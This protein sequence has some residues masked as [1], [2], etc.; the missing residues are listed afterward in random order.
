MKSKNLLAILAAFACFNLPAV[1]DVIT[2]TGATS[3]S[4]QTSGNRVIAK[5]IDGSGLSNV[6]DP[7]SELDDVHPY[8]SSTTDSPYWLSSGAASAEV[9]TFELGGSHDID[10]VYYWMYTRDKNRNPRTFDISYSTDG[11]SSFST[12]VSAASLNMADW[13]QSLGT[14]EESFAELR[15]LD[16][17]TGVTHIRFTNIQVY[18]GGSNLVGLHEIRFRGQETSVVAGPVDAGTSTVV[19]SP[20]AVLADGTSTSTITVTLKDASGIAVSGEDVT[21]ANTSGPGTPTIS[22]SATQT[23]DGSGVAT[24]TVSS[25]AVGTEVFSATSSTDS[26]T[27][28]QTASVDFQAMTVDAASSTVSASPTSVTANDTDTSS[29]TVTVRNAGGLPLPGMLVVLSGDSSATITP[30][31]TGTDTTDA[32]G[33]ATFT[34][35][36]GV[37]GL[38]TFTATSETVAITDTASVEFTAPVVVGPVDAGNS[39]VVAAPTS[40]AADGS[41]TSLIT[42]TLKD[43]AGLAVANEGVTLNITSGPGAATILPVDIQST[44]A[45]GQATFTVSSSTPGTEVFTATSITD[46][47]IIT[48]TASVEFIEVGATQL[49]TLL[50]AP[51]AASTSATGG[52]LT[53]L[54]DTSMSLTYVGTST[55]T[56]GSFRWTPKD[57]GSYAGDS[58]K[59][60]TIIYD[61]GEIVTFDGFIHAQALESDYSSIGSIDF[62]VSNTDPGSDWTAIAN[63]Y[64][65]TTPAASKA[66]N[67]GDRNLYEYVLDGAKLTGRYVIMRW[68]CQEQETDIGSPGGYTFYLGQTA[69]VGDYD[70]WAGSYP[71]V[72]GPTGDDDFDGLSN[73]YERLF[74]L[75]PLNAGSSN[76]YA[77]AFDPTAGTFSYTRR[78][79]S[80]TGMTYK[81]WYSTNLTEWFW[82]SGAG[83]SVSAPVADIETVQVTIDPD[84]LTEPR[85]F[86][87]MSAEDLG[88]APVISSLWGANTTVTVNFSEAMGGSAA[89]PANYTIEQDGGGTVAVTGAS[90]S[91]DGR[92][93]T[94]TLASALDIGSSFTVT[95]NRIANGVGQPLGNGT[96]AQ[97]QTWDDDPAGIKV[98]IL[99]GQSNMVG[100]GHTET[101]QTGDGGIGTLRYLANNNATYPEYDY[102]SLL[103]TPGDPVNSSWRTRGDV[104][105]WW[106][107]GASGNLPTASSTPTK[108]DLGP[109]FHG[110]DSSLIGPEYAF[111]QIIGDYYAS[112]DVLIIKAAWGGHKLAEDFRP[113]SAVAARGGE[114]GLSYLEIF[115]NAREV[116]DNLGTEFP[117]WAGRGYQIVGFAWHQGT[118]DK[119]PIERALEYKYNLPDF[120]S[121]VRAEF[122]KPDLPFVIATA[123]MTSA[124]VEPSPYPGYSDVER[125]QLWV[126]PESPQPAN[127][128]STDTRPFWEDAAVSPRDQGFHWNGNARS[129]F[130]VGKALGD[131]M[132]TLLSAP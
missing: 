30:A 8:I 108:G 126:F 33:E 15:A 14:R 1:A 70:T 63:T 40:V 124:G 128:L 44:D 19:A 62:W 25:G 49:I 69:S 125:A 76:P 84:L 102:T 45:N 83:E 100:Y 117:D 87:Q 82:E 131:D 58:V 85:L 3:T 103:A 13:S 92:T 113:P 97:F 26:V 57:S 5:T 10:G 24:F 121:D 73:E 23:T 72:G 32:N 114:V 71:G 132:V 105:V 81:V 94:L 50:N 99:A 46:S 41:E 116:L 16:T 122:G 39:T 52:T 28:T 12:P 119:S 91:G 20:T 31:G 37:V 79:Q 2:P 88:P 120:I 4:W 35:K 21:L 7:S 68:I 34:V 101:G 67:R 111:G 110:A 43:A 75:N 36:S 89:D 22:P 123:G 55:N 61:M 96:S 60:Q 93:A 48:Q 74:G 54:F 80:L 59:S 11:G 106:Y 53:N 9:V 115:N 66:L 77:A 129:Y 107:N 29:I 51:V 109:P 64:F 112:D 86:V 65:G 95:A 6:S 18:G 130:R 98:F 118:S 42:V 17:L 127:V 90:L 56:G 104:K 38:E 78:T 47:V 27:V